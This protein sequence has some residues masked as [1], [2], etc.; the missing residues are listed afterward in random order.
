MERTQVQV[1]I[2][3]HKPVNSAPACVQKI[4]EIKPV[5]VKKKC[6][7]C[8]ADWPHEKKCPAYGKTCHKCSGAN[9][10]ATVCRDKN[11]NNQNNQKSGGF[12]YQD[13]KKIYTVS[14]KNSSD[15]VR[16]NAFD[17]YS[18]TNNTST[19]KYSCEL[20]LNGVDVT[21]QVDSGADVTT[22]NNKLFQKINGGN[23]LLT[24]SDDNFPLL[25]TYTGETVSIRPIG[26]VNVPVEHHN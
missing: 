14:S 11:G 1:N 22:V 16:E 13:R 20:K 2:M 12:Q 18:I 9:Y 8:G 21:L 15:E 7:N 5:V 19:P 6:F 24:I 17:M 23:E 10:F 25:K 26:V 4:K 3:E